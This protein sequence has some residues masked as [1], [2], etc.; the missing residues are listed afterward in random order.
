MVIIKKK[1]LIIKFVFEKLIEKRFIN[2]QLTPQILINN[3]I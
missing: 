1:R 3:M 2:A